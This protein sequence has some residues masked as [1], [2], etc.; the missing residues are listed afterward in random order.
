MDVS[1]HPGSR[2]AAPGT[3]RRT[4]APVTTASPRP[5]ARGPRAVDLAGVTPIALDITDPASVAAAAQAAGGVEACILIEEWAC[6]SPDFVISLAGPLLA[7]PPVYQAGTP[8]QIQRFVAPF[9]T[10]HGAPI[11]AMAFS[12]PEG[13]ANFA[14][15]PP[16]EGLRTTAVPDG[17]CGSSTAARH[18][19]PI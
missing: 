8:E 7:L 15:P 13:T 12:E 10:D 9:L 4:R 19:P 14:A 1:R 2:P 6:H 18:G 16:A 17:D 5:A 11:A 3:P